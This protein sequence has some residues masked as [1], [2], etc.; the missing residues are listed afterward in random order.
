FFVGQERDLEGEAAPDTHEAAAE[1]HPAGEGEAEVAV[2]VQED[3]TGEIEAEEAE[4]RV[5]VEVPVTRGVVQVARA[6]LAYLDREPGVEAEQ[7]QQGYRAGELELEA[8]VDALAP[9][10]CRVEGQRAV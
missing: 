9:L 10:P 6:G 2:R 8:G 3:R 1:L 4:A 5:G 7:P